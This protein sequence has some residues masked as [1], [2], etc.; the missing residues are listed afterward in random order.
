MESIIEY[1]FLRES[2]NLSEK[3]LEE[4]ENGQ[5]LI[6]LTEFKNS[7]D[8]KTLEKFENF[9]SVYEEERYKQEKQIYKKGFISGVKLATEI[10]GKTNK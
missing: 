1:L 10:Y 7:L 6:F 5:D 4:F 3:E 8:K 2:E 9:F